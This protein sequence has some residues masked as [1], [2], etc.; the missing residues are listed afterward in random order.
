MYYLILVISRFWDKIAEADV[1]IK[2][3]LGI[4]YYLQVFKIQN[5]NE[6]TSGAKMYCTDSTEL[7]RG[8]V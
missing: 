5:G 1:I 4:L 2:R 6:I 7:G 3:F 8:R